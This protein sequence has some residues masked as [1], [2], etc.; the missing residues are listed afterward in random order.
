MLPYKN[1]YIQKYEMFDKKLHCL[2][3]FLKDL[4]KISFFL[5]DK[6]SHKFG[7]KKLSYFSV[8]CI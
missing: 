4:S 8:C 7:L 1:M 2:K 5:T 3:Y 6:S